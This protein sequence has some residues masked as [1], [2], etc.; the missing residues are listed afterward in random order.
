MR[1]NVYCGNGFWV[2]TVGLPSGRPILEVKSIALK[3]ANDR[4]FSIFKRKGFAPAVSRCLGVGEDGA[5]NLS[6]CLGVGQGGAVVG[7]PQF[8]DPTG[9][10]R[11]LRS[12]R[13]KHVSVFFGFGQHLVLTVHTLANKE[14]CAMGGIANGGSGAGICAIGELEP[15]A[16]GTQH[17]I[18]RVGVPLVG[19]GF[20][21]LQAVPERQGY[22]LFFGAGCIKL[23]GTGQG[24]A[25]TI[26]G[27][28]VVN[29]KGRDI[30]VHKVH[31][32]II[33]IKLAHLHVKRQALG[34]AAQGVYHALC[35]H[36]AYDGERLCTPHIAHGEQQPGQATDVVCMQVGNEDFIYGFKAE[37]CFLGGN[38]G[39]FSAVYENGVPLVA[40]HQ[41]GEPTI[42]E[43]LG[44][45]G[46]Q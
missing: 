18:G 8:L 28:A 30:A 4:K 15:L 5:R 9:I 36:G 42:N 45:T 38:L 26:A 46:S 34:N 16:G 6:E 23:T 3:F 20:S 44:A 29:G 37:P 1:T 17:H 2:I 35:T 10:C 39:A 43:G 19:D 33:C 7:E 25:V 24:E 14:V 41:R 32:L 40:H 12:L 11:E 27:H 13:E 22:I 31:E 21:L